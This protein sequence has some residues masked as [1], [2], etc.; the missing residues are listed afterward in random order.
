VLRYGKWCLCASSGVYGRKEMIDV[1]KTERGCWEQFYLCSM[2]LCIY[3]QWRMSP[4]LI[5]YSDFLVCF[6]SAS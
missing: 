4:L 5:S 2:I 3:G 1:L 6:A